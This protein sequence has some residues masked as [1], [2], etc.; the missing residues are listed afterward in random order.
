MKKSVILSLL[1]LLGTALAEQITILGI[2]DMHANVDNLPQLA[3]CVQQEREKAPQ[4]LL[5]SAGDNRTGNPYVDCGDHPGAAMIQLMNHI[6]FDLSALGNH[7]FDA[8]AAAIADTPEQLYEFL[9]K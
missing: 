3:T 7:E 1:S 2:N 6:G 5:L 9:T 8:G 4:L